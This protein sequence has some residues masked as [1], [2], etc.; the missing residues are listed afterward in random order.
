M[1]DPADWDGEL[2]AYSASECTRLG[3]G[4]VMRI[5]RHA[6]AHEAGLPQHELP[7]VL[8]AQA[9]R[10]CPKRPTALLRDRFAAAVGVFSAS[11]TAPDTVLWSETV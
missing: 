4:E 9:N 10:L 8:I 3:K 1:V 7:V 2:V 11:D 5:R 6:A